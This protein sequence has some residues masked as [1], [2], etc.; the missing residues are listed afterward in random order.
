MKHTIFT[1]LYSTYEYES[2]FE[3]SD[4]PYSYENLEWLNTT[5]QK[6]TLEELTLAV[7]SLNAEE[8]YKQ[9][10]VLRN[11]KLEACDWVT[12]KAY[13]QGVAVSEEWSTYLQALRDI[14]DTQS[15]SLDDNFELDLTSF[16]W[17]TKPE[18]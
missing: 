15:P 12:I 1:Y 4:E 11:K 17:P 2:D 5:I 9:L 3:W 16:V 8:P 6:P 14:T 10:R 13:S 18:G 7:D